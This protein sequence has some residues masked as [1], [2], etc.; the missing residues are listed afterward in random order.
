MKNIFLIIAFFSLVAFS[1][2]ALAG[3]NMDSSGPMGLPFSTNM[4][5]KTEVDTSICPAGARTV[6]AFL[7]AW[8]KEDFPAMYELLTD[9]S[10]A[11]YPYDQTRFTFQFLELIGWFPGTDHHTVIFFHIG[12]R[13]RGFIQTIISQ[14]TVQYQVEK[15]KID[16]IYGFY[17]LNHGIV[18]YAYGSTVVHHYNFSFGKTQIKNQRTLIFIKIGP[19]YCEQRILLR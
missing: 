13:I 19:A 18:F 10:K 14:I 5:G 2:P 1:S 16:K 7:K 4:G 8:K 6:T 9:D 3:V 12:K 15:S 17:Y 11:K